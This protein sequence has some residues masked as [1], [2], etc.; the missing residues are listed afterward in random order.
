[1]MDILYQLFY[2]IFSMSCMAIVLLPVVLILRI[3]LRRLS[4]NLTLVL[5][6]ILFLR[7]VCPVGMSSPVCLYEPW[8]RQ[9]HRLIRSL[10]L[11]ILPDK[12]LLTGWKYVFQG[13]IETTM[14][15]RI[16]T[17]I[18]LVGV[19]FLIVGTV[20]KQLRLGAALRKHS[21]H[22]FDRI[23]QSEIISCP[24]R[25]GMLWG[26]IYLPEGLLAKEMRDIISYQQLRKV[27]MDDAWRRMAF[28]VCCIHCGIRVYGSHITCSGR[29]KMMRVTYPF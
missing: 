1:M 19:V 11:Q 16:C 23:Y 10:G 12:G 7:A 28:V 26:R 9:F 27:R 21:K 14:A 24:V 8:N 15:Y 4:G 3:L 29:I 17:L 20:W 22:L 2:T 18:W 5:W 13:N 25:T 6:G